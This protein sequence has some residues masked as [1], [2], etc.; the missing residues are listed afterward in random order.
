[1]GMFSMVFNGQETEMKFRLVHRL[2]TERN[3]TVVM[4]DP[5]AGRNVKG[6]SVRYLGQLKENEGVLLAVCS[7]EYAEDQLEE[8]KYEEVKFAF[9]NDLEIVPLRV[10]D[11]Y[12]P[13]RPDP[14]YATVGKSS[15]VDLL[16]SAIP[17]W[18]VD[19]DCRRLDEG[20]IASRIAKRLW[21]P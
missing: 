20:E 11:T 4:A 7:P 8:T 9:D 3:Y 10:S 17:R 14:R 6:D 21:E 12:L 1:M 13:E 18:A 5:Q 2:L 19:V 15:M 16:R